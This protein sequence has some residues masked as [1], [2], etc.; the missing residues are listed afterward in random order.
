LVERLL[1]VG[2]EAI[3][4]VPRATVDRLVGELSRLV[5]SLEDDAGHS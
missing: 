4:G 1:A 5:S 3:D 2:N